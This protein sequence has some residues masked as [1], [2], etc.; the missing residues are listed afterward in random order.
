MA[1]EITM[2]KFMEFHNTV[3]VNNEY[4]IRNIF[5]PKIRAKTNLSMKEWL[6]LAQDYQKFA[7]VW[8]HGKDVLIDKA[9][10]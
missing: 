7:D 6:V 8:L 3:I 1:I 5:N 9:N 2:E 4:G 10:E